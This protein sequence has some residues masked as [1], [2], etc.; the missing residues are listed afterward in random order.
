MP[1]RQYW[2]DLS[3]L[4]VQQRAPRAMLVSIVLEPHPCVV[5][6]MTKLPHRP[7]RREGQH[8]DQGRETFS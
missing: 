3:I 5:S 4:S 1:R 7:F 2:H 6:G 8:A